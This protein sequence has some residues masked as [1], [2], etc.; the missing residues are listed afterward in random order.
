MLTPAHSGIC[1]A[2][3]SF[4]YQPCKSEASTTLA[5]S[6]TFI[7][8]SNQ[9]VEFPVVYVTPN[10]CPELQTVYARVP[11]ATFKQKKKYVSKIFH[12]Y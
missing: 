3:F 12:L 2:G 11:K 1:A 8:E 5:Q 4:P 10:L 6:S 9:I 7:F